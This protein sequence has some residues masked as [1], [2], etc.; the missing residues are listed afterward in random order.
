M[1]RLFIDAA[2]VAFV[3]VTRRKCE[4]TFTLRTIFNGNV[5]LHCKHTRGHRGDCSYEWHG[6]T[7]RL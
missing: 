4:R 5:V 1:L 6:H 7:F 2:R 3:Y